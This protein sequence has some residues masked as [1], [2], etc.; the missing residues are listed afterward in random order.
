MEY[1]REINREK[2]NSIYDILIRCGSA[3]S[4]RLSFIYNFCKA[5]LPPIYW[6]FIGISGVELTYWKSD[7]CITAKYDKLFEFCGIEPNEIIQFCNLDL[8]NIK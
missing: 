6:D 7:N 1:S 3:E 4:D 5:E 8:K 2:I